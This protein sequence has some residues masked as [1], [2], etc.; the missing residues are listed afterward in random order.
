MGTEL[1][2][3]GFQN[4]EIGA[5]GRVIKIF[6]GVNRLKCKRKKGTYLLFKLQEIKKIFLQNLI[7]TII[8]LTFDKLLLHLDNDLQMG[9]EVT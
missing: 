5:T 8:I 6:Q 9:S 2:I 7:M 4:L 1:V 3:R